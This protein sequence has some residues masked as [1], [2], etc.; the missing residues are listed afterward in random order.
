MVGPQPKSSPA[1]DLVG[2]DP[3]D[4]SLWPISAARDLLPPPPRATSA[5][6]SWRIR[7]KNSSG[8]R[9]GSESGRAAQVCEPCFAGSWRAGA[10]GIGLRGPEPRRWVDAALRV[11]SRG[12]TPT[13]A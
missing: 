1:T 3:E 5:R 7:T 8:G 9:N 12:M 2:R 13:A 6:L 11:S 10:A 4:N